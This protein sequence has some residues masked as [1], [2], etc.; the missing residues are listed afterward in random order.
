MQSRVVRMTSPTSRD[1]SKFFVKYLYPVLTNMISEEPLSRELMHKHDILDAVLDVTQRFL[2]SAEIVHASCVF[3]QVLFWQH[4][5]V[6]D[7]RFIDPLVQKCKLELFLKIAQKYSKGYS[8]NAEVLMDA[9]VIVMT[10]CET[11]G[12]FQWLTKN[13]Y[14]MRPFLTSFHRMHSLAAKTEER[15][16]IKNVLSAFEVKFKEVEQK[17]AAQ[18]EVELLRRE[19]QVLAKRSKKQEKKRMRRQKKAEQR[20]VTLEPVK[21]SLAE[22]KLNEFPATNIDDQKQETRSGVKVNEAR[23]EVKKTDDTS[24]VIQPP[25]STLH[26]DNI[27]DEYK[28][29]KNYGFSRMMDVGGEFVKAISKKNQKK[30]FG[31][32]PSGTNSEKKSNGTPEGKKSN[33]PNDGAA[34]IANG[35]RSEQGSSKKKKKKRNESLTYSARPV[36]LWY[37]SDDL[38]THKRADIADCSSSA[39][40]SLNKSFA[41]VVAGKNK[42]VTSN[43]ETRPHLDIV[44]APCY[45]PNACDL[46]DAKLEKTIQRQTATVHKLTPDLTAKPILPSASASTGGTLDAADHTTNIIKS[47]P[48]MKMS[49]VTASTPACCPKAATSSCT[50]KNDSVCWLKVGPTVVNRKKRAGI[51]ALPRQNAT[52]MSHQKYN[53]AVT[54]STQTTDRKVAVVTATRQGE[55]DNVEQKSQEPNV[56]V[57]KVVSTASSESYHTACDMRDTEEDDGSHS[58]TDSGHSLVP[59]TTFSESNPKESLKKLLKLLNLDGFVTV[60]NEITKLDNSESNLQKQ[61]LN[62]RNADEECSNSEHVLKL[63]VEPDLADSPEAR[64]SPRNVSIDLQDEVTQD[65]LLKQITGLSHADE[66]K[67]SSKLPQL[68]SDDASSLKPITSTNAF[69]ADISCCNDLKTLDEDHWSQPLVFSNQASS[70]LPVCKQLAASMSEGLI[71]STTSEECW[72]KERLNRTHD[73]VLEVSDTYRGDSTSDSL[74]ESQ[75]MEQLSSENEHVAKTTEQL[76]PE[77][78]HLTQFTS[79]TTDH[80]NAACN[81]K[82]KCSNVFDSSREMKSESSPHQGQ[83]YP[84]NIW[85][86]RMHVA[87]PY[88]GNEA[89]QSSYLCAEQKISKS[90][91]TNENFTNTA[92]PLP[93]YEHKMCD[94]LFGHGQLSKLPAHTQHNNESSHCNITE[95]APTYIGY[96]SKNNILVGEWPD[97]CIKSSKTQWNNHTTPIDRWNSSSE[98]NN[99]TAPI[100]RWNGPSEKNDRTALMD[101]LIEDNQKAV[102]DNYNRWEFSSSNHLAPQA[103][104]NTLLEKAPCKEYNCWQNSTQEL[105]PFEQL[106]KH[107][108]QHIEQSTTQQF[109]Q[110][111]SNVNLLAPQCFYTVK[112]NDADQQLAW[113]VSNLQNFH[114][115][116]HRPVAQVF[117]SP[118]KLSAVN[119]L[120]LY[121]NVVPSNSRTYGV[122]QNM[123][124]R[125]YGET[126]E[127][128]NRSCQQGANG[129]HHIAITEEDPAIVGINVKPREF[130]RNTDVATGRRNLGNLQFELSQMTKSSGPRTS[131]VSISRRWYQ[132]FQQLTTLPADRLTTKGCVTFCN[133]DQFAISRR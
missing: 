27:Y 92:Q 78:E 104:M 37:S 23:N 127:T 109:S 86:N 132:A 42:P 25:K 16:D 81:I 31:P 100:D 94:P 61:D 5:D 120:C 85:F 103:N 63:T 49:T 75:I 68:Q 87:V 43:Q 6:M 125:C 26:D 66:T 102:P 112:E 7:R 133:E 88:H 82:S 57:K 21:N 58:D 84:G 19:E 30:I 29:G 105:L 12:G 18:N 98:M 35:V 111:P 119:K 124:Q 47:E 33:C 115:R 83:N 108:A 93:L 52:S 90:R 95:Q 70:R 107:A 128:N 116:Q 24:V 64:D 110:K 74:S 36:G 41:A 13:Y 60:S 55:D 39:A 34:A 38:P 67:H 62:G 114:E 131:W 11:E 79:R 123:T 2:N 126:V 32:K 59:N 22:E 118:Q 1:T 129:K 71:P 3:C 14:K 10:L 96:E 80:H 50:N 106:R 117:P 45:R 48:D 20:Q 121:Q 17:M 28:R 122:K 54:N 44:N 15:R 40:R 76:S 65:A 72:K 9:L 99:H 69:S 97:E 130:K 4:A 91:P 51:E 46:E 101:R 53:A 89:I 8:E 113:P 77:N 73:W 56:N